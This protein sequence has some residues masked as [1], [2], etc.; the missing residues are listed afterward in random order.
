[1]FYPYKS[2]LL[3]SITF[4]VYSCIRVGKRIIRSAI[5][6]N[7]AK[8]SLKAA[9]GSFSEPLEMVIYPG[10]GLTSLRIGKKQEIGQAHE[11]RY[12]D[13]WIF[14][15]GQKHLQ[16]AH[17]VQKGGTGKWSQERPEQYLGRVPHEVQ[18]EVDEHAPG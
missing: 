2:I 1:M 12:G 13:D 15:A 16:I 11:F 14:Q 3:K 17:G 18:R 8:E 6:S 7:F 10:Q 5:P 4:R 9:D